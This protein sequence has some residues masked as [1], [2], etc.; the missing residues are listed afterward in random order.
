M[1][2]PAEKITEVYNDLQTYASHIAENLS[3]LTTSQFH[4]GF[5]I[6]IK[7]FNYYLS[8]VIPPFFGNYDAYCETAL[9]DDNNLMYINNLGYGLEDDGVKV[10]YDYDELIT[11]IEYIFESFE[12]FGNIILNLFRRKKAG[13]KIA[14]FI[15]KHKDEFLYNPYDGRVFSKCLDHFELVKSKK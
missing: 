6:K 4:N 10:F 3:E 14:E 7:N 8:V 11:E 12:K 2:T 5:T 13:K 9:R 1:T 15:D